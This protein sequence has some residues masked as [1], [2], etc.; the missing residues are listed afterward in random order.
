MCFLMLFTMF[1][2][3]GQDPALYRHLDVLPRIQA[4]Q[5]GLDTVGAVLV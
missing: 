2:V 5:L 4:R 1:S 3:D